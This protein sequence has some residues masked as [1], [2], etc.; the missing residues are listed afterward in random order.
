MPSRSVPREVFRPYTY[1]WSNGQTGPVISNLAAGF[2]TV[3]VRDSSA[4]ACQQVRVFQITQPAAALTV[5]ATATNSNCP[6]S[7]GTV[8][9]FVSGGVVPYTYLWSN[10]ATS[11]TISNVANGTYTVSVRDANNCGPVTASATVGCN[12]NLRITCPP[13]RNQQCPADYSPYAQGGLPTFTGCESASMSYTDSFAAG[14]GN[15]GAPSRAC[16]RRLAATRPC[17]AHRR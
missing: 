14:C 2:Y 1:S 13:N 5:T 7:T 16:G 9:A 8:S 17:R 12:A 4:V 10:G 11:Q 3:T 15:T 6:S